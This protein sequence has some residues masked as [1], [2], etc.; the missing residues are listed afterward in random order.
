ME[1]PK[2]ILEGTRIQHRTLTVLRHRRWEC[3]VRDTATT[4]PLGVPT[5]RDYHGQVIADGIQNRMSEESIT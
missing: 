3:L 5:R 1:M 2:N 4:F